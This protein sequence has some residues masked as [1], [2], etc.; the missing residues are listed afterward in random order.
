[1]ST[2]ASLA[3]I[4]PP[5][6]ARLGAPVA[7]GRAVRL[8]SRSPRRGPLSLSLEKATPDTL[9]ALTTSLAEIVLARNGESVLVAPFTHDDAV[10]LY[11]LA[12]GVGPHR[13]V[14]FVARSAAVPLSRGTAGE[15]RGQREGG[16]KKD[17]GEEKGEVV[18]SVQLHF[19]AAP[20]GWF[21]ADVRGLM[22]HPDYGRRGIARQLM[23]AVEEEAKACKVKLLLADTER[24]SAG[25]SVFTSAGFTTTGIVPRYTYSVD[26]LLRD[27]ALMHKELRCGNCDECGCPTEKKL[28]W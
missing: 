1:M 6:S 23:E 16:E 15:R 7:T 28:Q 20:N 10:Q 14:L 8:R 17:D 13:C 25:H 5:S 9:P 24:D 11:D 2:V 27:G 21:R 4:D 12:L 18:G 22:V 3:P 26:G 19:H